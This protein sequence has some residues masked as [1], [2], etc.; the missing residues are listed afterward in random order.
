MR[1]RFLYIILALLFA[2]CN[3]FISAD[4]RHKNK[5]N[6]KIDKE[7]A[8]R[9][10]KSAQINAKCPGAIVKKVIHDTV[11]VEVEIPA[12]DID[13]FLVIEKDTALIDSLVNL[14]RN[15]KTREI[16]R[17][18]IKE[19]V[20][21]KDTVIHL[22]DG[23]TIKFWSKDGKINYTIDK[24]EQTIV[25]EVPIETIVEELKP[26][27][28][29]WWEKLANGLTRYL[30]VLILIVLFFLLLRYIKKKFF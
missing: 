5:C 12:T 21:I 23:F 13:S 30:W 29:S 24:P 17:K 3:P 11:E 18:Y 9:D 20:P 26:L 19:Y 28:L 7:L 14:I 8:R 1:A 27:E 4:L 6:R 2:S 16:I 15:N 22:A 10:K 25:E